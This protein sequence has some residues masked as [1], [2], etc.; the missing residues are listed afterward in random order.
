[1]VGL[2]VNLVVN[3]IL[4]PR[5]GIVGASAASLVSYSCHAA[6]LLAISSRWAHVSPFAFILP[7]RAEFT[8]VW[9]SA[10][11]VLAIVRAMLWRRGRPAGGTAVGG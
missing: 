6:I 8:R 7:R 5:W 9:G 4:I 2:S 11:G 3:L 1:M 10:R